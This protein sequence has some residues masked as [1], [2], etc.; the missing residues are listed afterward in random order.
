MKDQ[1][2]YFK[3]HITISRIETSQCSICGGAVVWMDIYCNMEHGWK[4]VLLYVH[5]VCLDARTITQSSGQTGLLRSPTGLTGT[6]T[7]HQGMRQATVWFYTPGITKQ[8]VLVV[9]RTV[10]FTYC[11]ILVERE[12]MTEKSARV[13]DKATLVV[14]V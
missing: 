6:T 9:I 1:G 7:G 2:G 8:E 11:C 13:K 4:R 14:N 12:N 3:E 5:W 10:S